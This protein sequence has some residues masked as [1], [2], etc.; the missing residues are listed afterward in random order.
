MIDLSGSGSCR[1]LCPRLTVAAR[2]LERQVSLAGTAS[3]QQHTWALNIVHW[4]ESRINVSKSP[5]TWLCVV[6]IAAASA[7]CCSTFKPFV[8][9]NDTCHDDNQTGYVYADGRSATCL[10][11]KDV[12]FMICARELAMSQMESERTNKTEGAVK[13]EYAGVGVAANL[14]N[15]QKDKLAAKWAADGEL[16]SARAAAIRHCITLSDSKAPSAAAAPPSS[17]PPSSAMPP[18]TSK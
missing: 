15:E 8:F 13:G 9:G 17:A 18:A 4:N 10:P 14:S 11:T 3:Q 7:G 16:S 5:G 6:A 1:L 12:V 2:S